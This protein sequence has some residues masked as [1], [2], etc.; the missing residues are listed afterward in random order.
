M[1]EYWVSQGRKMCTYCKCWTADNKASIAFHEQGKKH[2]EMVKLKLDE[3]RKKGLEDARN[4]SAEA[5]TM[6]AI[7]RAA[8]ESFKK[9]I[10]N[11]S[12]NDVAMA[13][14]SVES[15]KSQMAPKAPKEDPQLLKSLPDSSSKTSP[16]D[17][18][19]VG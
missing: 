8:M 12:G 5:D 14:G 3:L 10:G 13:Y 19:K 7:E 9:D 11:K 4:K 1:S 18:E 15:I 16:D 2:K 6:A 17:F